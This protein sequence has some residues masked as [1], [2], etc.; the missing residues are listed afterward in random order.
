[1]KVSGFKTLNIK[2][3]HKKTHYLDGDQTFV[4]IEVLS[5]EKKKDGWLKK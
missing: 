4:T 2:T 3:I 1:M 5:E